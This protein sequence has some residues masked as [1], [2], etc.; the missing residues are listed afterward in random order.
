MTTEGKKIWI[1]HAAP[2]GSMKWRPIGPDWFTSQNA[3]KVTRNRLR[4]EYKATTKFMVVPY[5]KCKTWQQ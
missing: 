5:V 3:A 2:R 1:V 4:D